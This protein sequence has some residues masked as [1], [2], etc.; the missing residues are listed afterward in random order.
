MAGWLLLGVFVCLPLCLCFC[1]YVCV[2]V[3]LPS[4]LVCLINVLFFFSSY[5][6]IASQKQESVCPL[7]RVFLRRSG[8]TLPSWRLF[9]FVRCCCLSLNLITFCWHTV[10]K[11]WKNVRGI[12]RGRSPNWCWTVPE[13]VRSVGQSAGGAIINSLGHPS[14]RDLRLVLNHGLPDGHN[15]VLQYYLQDTSLTLLWRVPYS[16]V[17]FVLWSDLTDCSSFISQFKYIL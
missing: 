6:H 4:L 16:Q 17:T 11:K 7:W 14:R 1:N 5:F 9:V 2:C 15:I 13:E 8:V 10:R 3:C 12:W